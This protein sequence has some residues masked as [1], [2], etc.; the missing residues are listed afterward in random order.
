MKKKNFIVGLI[1]GVAVAGIILLCWLGSLTSSTVL[2]KEHGRLFIV[3]GS[4]YDPRDNC[5]I[6]WVEKDSMQ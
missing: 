3:E 1:V 4:E 2:I 6:V 5:I